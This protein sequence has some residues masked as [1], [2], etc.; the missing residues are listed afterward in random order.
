MCLFKFP[1][2]YITKIPPIFNQYKWYI[3]KD[4]YQRLRNWHFFTKGPICLPQIIS[5]I[6]TVR[7]SYAMWLNYRLSNINPSRK[8][9]HEIHNKRNVSNTFCLKIMMLL[10]LGTM[11]PKWKWVCI[12]VYFLLYEDKHSKSLCWEAGML[13]E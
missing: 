1:S 10:T 3:Q 11:V 9:P 2:K 8:F 5:I 6:G 7:N 12:I 4:R 13:Q